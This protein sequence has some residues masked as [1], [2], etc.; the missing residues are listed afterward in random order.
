MSHGKKHVD[1]VTGIET[2]GHV[3]DGLRELNNPLPKWWLYILYATIVWAVV[4]M[5]LFPA[6][7]LLERAWPGTGCR[8]PRA[9]PCPRRPGRSHRRRGGWESPRPAAC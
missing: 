1:D 2:T 3:W 8:G 9:W 6:F 7:P 4:Y 5:I